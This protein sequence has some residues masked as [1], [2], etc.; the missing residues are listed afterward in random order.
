MKLQLPRRRVWREHL[1][2]FNPQPLDEASAWIDKTRAFWNSTAVGRRYSGYM[3][4]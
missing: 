2:S 3:P 4:N 1:V